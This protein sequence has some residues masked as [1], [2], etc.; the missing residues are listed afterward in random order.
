MLEYTP[1]SL[2]QVEA[3][4]PIAVDAPYREHG[5]IRPSVERLRQFK[6]ALEAANNAGQGVLLADVCI[7]L[8]VQQPKLAYQYIGEAGHALQRTI[9]VAQ[10]KIPQA[11]HVQGQVYPVMALSLVRAA[12]LGKWEQAIEK[13]RVKP[14]YRSL[15][16]AASKASL[17]A[18]QN[19]SAESTLIEATPV[20][21]GARA[22]ERGTGPG[23]LGRTA[24]IR[25][26][27][28][29]FAAKNWDCG[30]SY[31]G[32]DFIDPRIKLQIKKNGNRGTDREEAAK[33]GILTISAGEH[34]FA[35]VLQLVNGCLLENGLKS[36]PGAGGK[37]YSTD[38]LDTITGTLDQAVRDFYV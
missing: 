20:L 36:N 28:G 27:K 21:L 7:D 15:L 26:D 8:A 13:E 9:L 37:P 17:S 18:G 31:S 25:E 34:G 30:L 11:T 19:T 6:T 12:E 2:A 10:S 35:N 24:L 32:D 3:G 4:K 22:L 1:N 16:E 23:W 5:G 38:Q 14:Q 29:N 33:H